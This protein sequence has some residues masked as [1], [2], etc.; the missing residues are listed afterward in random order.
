M[1]AARSIREDFL[2][3][4][5]FH[6]ID[7]YTPLQKQFRMMKLVLAFYEQSK[8]ALE[9]GASIQNLIK[10]PVR[11]QIGRFKYVTEDKL[12]EEFKQVDETLSAQIAAAF[13]K[14]EG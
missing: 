6:E 2:H 3:Q 10:M 5:S 8:K 13:V 7:T 4:N 9:G 12:D 1:E 14:E 11:E